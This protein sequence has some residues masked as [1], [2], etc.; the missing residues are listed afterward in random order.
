MKVGEGRRQHDERLSS[1]LH[2]GSEGRLELFGL[3]NL[4]SV[5][6]HPQRLGRH[7]ALCPIRMAQWAEDGHAR[8][9]SHR[10][11]EEL[12]ALSS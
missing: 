7:G 1:F 2:G 5:E 8:H 12:Q 10:L 3:L 4:D 6:L 9:A 11:D